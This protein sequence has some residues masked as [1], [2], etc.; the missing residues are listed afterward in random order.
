MD[1]EDEK[2]RSEVIERV[3]KAASLNTHIQCKR[4]VSY[5]YL[6]LGSDQSGRQ[7]FQSLLR[8]M[9]YY[10]KRKAGHS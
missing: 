6:Q 4:A 3:M 9:G 1:L 5:Q 10:S 7:K 2:K 8:D